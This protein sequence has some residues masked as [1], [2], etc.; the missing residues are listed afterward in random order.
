MHWA[1]RL[2]RVFYIGIET[3]RVCGGTVKV[4]ATIEDPVVIKRI[5]DYLD[6]QTKPSATGL[7]PESREPPE[8]H[9]AAH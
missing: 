6:N 3:C 4:I 7:L 8:S 9:R 2:K 5:L 1:Q